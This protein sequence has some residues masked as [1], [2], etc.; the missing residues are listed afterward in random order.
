MTP[1]FEKRKADARAVEDRTRA[2][3]RHMDADV[4]RRLR[5]SASAAQGT[6]KTIHR[7]NMALRQQLGLPSFLDEKQP[8]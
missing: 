7:D 5:V 2:E 3:G 6:L 8:R 1:R 4:I